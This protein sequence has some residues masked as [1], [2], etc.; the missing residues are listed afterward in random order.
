VVG[1]GGFFAL[2][3]G[4]IVGSGW[5]VLLGEWLRL[6]APAG[7][8][9]A[10]LAGG[11]LM[12]AIGLCYAELA[13]RMPRAGA[14][15]RYVADTLGPKAAFPV[16]WFLTLFLVAICAF[17]G[18]ALPWLLGLLLPVRAAPLYRFLG[19]PVTGWGLSVGCLGAAAI[20]VLNLGGVQLSVLFQRVI[21]YAFLAVMVSLIIAGLVFGKLENLQPAFSPPGG[22]SWLLGFTWLFATCAMLLYGF[23]SALYLIEERAPH[24]SVRAATGSMVIGI[25][26]AALF[27]AAVL[28]SAGSIIPWRSI[29]S[30]ELPSVAAFDALLPGRIAPVILVVAV[31]SLAKTWNAVIMMASRLVLAQ[32]QAGLL[33]AWLG[34]IDAHRKTPRN[35]L[36]L[37]TGASMIG[38]LLGRGAIVPIVNM[39]TI[40][41]S[42]TIALMLLVLIVQQRRQP[43]SPGFSVPA[44]GLVIP[45]CVVGAVLMAGF[46]LFQPLWVQ[47]GIPLE[48]KLIALWAALGFIFRLTLGRRPRC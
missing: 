4:S 45:V 27:Y 3:F 20:C 11:M 41:V 10:L 7:A 12:A 38:I 37:V 43:R 33:P 18:T 48:W 24:V 26:A 30:A 5:I 28:L 35:A 14:E 47:P 42:M 32:A 25:V 6:A 36:L 9:L 15:L 19:E 40:C 22:K 1:R 29:L 23:Q 17:E 21:T 16:G 34:R 39:A 2:S 8:L 44:P 46:A 13:A 31:F